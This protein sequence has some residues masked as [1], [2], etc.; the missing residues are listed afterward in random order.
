MINIFPSSHHH[1]EGARKKIEDQENIYIHLPS[2]TLERPQLTHEAGM[3]MS[4]IG[5]TETTHTPVTALSH[6]IL[7]HL[8]PN[9]YGF[10][11]CRPSSYF[12]H[13]SFCI[14]VAINKP[15]PPQHL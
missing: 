1:T 4:Q 9:F 3:A 11:F 2:H 12:L 8:Q 15:N 13:S 10:S 7:L 14:V 5:K 6:A